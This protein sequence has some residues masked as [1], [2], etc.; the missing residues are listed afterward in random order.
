MSAGCPAKEAN[1]GRKSWTVQGVD[2]ADKILRFRD[3]GWDAKYTLG[4]LAN[5]P[6]L[7]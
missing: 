7:G 1:A 2:Q 6:E 4:N 5:A 3:S